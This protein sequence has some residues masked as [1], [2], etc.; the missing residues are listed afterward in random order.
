MTPA[1]AKAAPK[2]AKTAAKASAHVDPT[3]KAYR[4]PQST[5]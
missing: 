1:K 2:A 4:S 5:G 3:R